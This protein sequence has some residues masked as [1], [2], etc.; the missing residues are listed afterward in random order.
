MATSN[1]DGF[2]KLLDHKKEEK[3]QIKYALR[4]EGGALCK[5][6][7][8]SIQLGIAYHHSGIAPVFEY[9]M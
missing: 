9:T 6:F 4:D 1:S 2:R 5:I 8:V 7:S 3:E